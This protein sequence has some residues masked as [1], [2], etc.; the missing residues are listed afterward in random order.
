M[1]EVEPHRLASTGNRRAGSEPDATTDV[2]VVGGGAAGLYVA[3][4]AAEQG[5]A[6]RARL[7]KA[8]RRERELLGAGRAGGGAGA[9]RLACPPRRRHPERRSRPVP[10]RGGRGADPRGARR[11][12]QELR[13]RGVR[14][15]TE[16][17][18]GLGLALE[19]GHSARR[20]VHAGGAQ[21][22][23][24]IT[25][26][27]AELVGRA[28]DG[29]RCSRRPRPSPCGATAAAAPGWSR[30]PGRSPPGP[31]CWRPAAA[32]R[33][34]GARRTRGARSAPAPFSPMPRGADARRPGVLP[35]PPHR[36]GAA[37]LRARRH[38]AD[39]GAPRR[40][41]RAARRVRADGSPTS[42]PRA[43]R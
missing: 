38:P 35:V 2:A 33:C 1:R 39:R 12:W 8:A 28:A 42:L 37:R 43:T 14:F 34:G 10:R 25:G 5:A 36:A 24:A 32:R 26:R 3:L 30:T 17:D 19:G 18:G 13:E 40:G 11:R 4:R 9:G 21:T 6:V 16:P 31:R 22:G 7:A 41:R 27:L 20:I 15:D 29:S 23:R